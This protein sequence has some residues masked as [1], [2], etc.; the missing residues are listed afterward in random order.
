MKAYE[1]VWRIKLPQRMPVI[2]RVDGKA[3][4]SLL[5]KADKP[6]DTNFITSMKLTVY[7]TMRNI[8]N[9]VFAYCQSDEVSFLLHNYKKLTTESWFDN[10]LQKMVSITAATMS[11]YFHEE[12]GKRAVFD[13]RAFIL[14]ETEVVNYFVWRQNDAVRNSIQAVGQA[15]FSQKELHEKSCEDIKEM[16]LKIDI[17]WNK[18]NN[19][20]KRGFCIK[21]G[22]IDNLI[23]RFSEDREYISELLK[24]EEE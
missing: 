19:V 17:D 18:E 5:A 3:F 4:H 23:P 14:P 24:I 12:Y 6:F 9:C 10:N 22:D 16:L 20:H 21:N 1:D 7:D 8:Q 11:L 15:N 2:I 13:A